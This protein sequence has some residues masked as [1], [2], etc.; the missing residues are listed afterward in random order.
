MLHVTG[1]GPLNI[2]QPRIDD[3]NLNGHD[4]FTSNILQRYLK[5]IPSIDNLFPLFIL[6]ISTSGFPSALSAILGEGIRGL[7]AANIVY[8]KES[9]E[10]DYIDY[11]SRNLS[12]KN[13]VY[14]WVD[15]IYFIVLLEDA[16]SC[17]LVII[18][19]AQE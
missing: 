17:I 14:F 5:R 6:G 9:W 4:R 15:G 8:L 10:K 2:T 12:H 1:M 19:A 13:Y 7:S 3:C 18:G 11:K 16:W